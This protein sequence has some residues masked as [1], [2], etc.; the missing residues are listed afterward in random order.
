MNDITVA[1]NNSISVQKGQV[2]FGG[3]EVI[4]RQCLEFLEYV[5]GLDI[6]EE[7][8][9]SAR[10]SAT[11][12]R[13]QKDVVEDYRKSVKR[14]LLEPY[15]VFEGQVKEI[16]GVIDEAESIIRHQVKVLDSIE[17]EEKKEKLK[18]LFDKRA[19]RY[20]THMTFEDFLEPRH[21][22]KG[23]SINQVELE[24]V[25]FLEA[26]LEDT[27]SLEVND[28]AD[29]EIHELTITLKTMSAKELQR[30]LTLLDENGISYF[31]R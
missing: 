20:Q 2:E 26:E 9:K 10:K 23:I 25:K 29:I 16:V 12:I 21:L 17:R 22:N 30:A 11:L 1:Y 18:Q 4:Y 24:M 5:K 7:N 27:V 28:S 31:V 14:E 19:S 15:M 3:Y 13:K 6:T 8:I